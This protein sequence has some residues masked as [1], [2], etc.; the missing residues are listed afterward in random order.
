MAAQCADHFTGH[1]RRAAFR[2]VGVSLAV[3]F[4]RRFE[5]REI[6]VAVAARN[7]KRPDAQSRSVSDAN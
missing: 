3:D 2:H 1:F 5:R 7:H 6:A 4:Q